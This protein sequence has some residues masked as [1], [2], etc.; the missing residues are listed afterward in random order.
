MHDYRMS[1][2]IHTLEW[3]CWEEKK[4]KYEK[5]EDMKTMTLCTLAVQHMKNK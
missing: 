3:W 4:V 5:R 1:T 2:Y